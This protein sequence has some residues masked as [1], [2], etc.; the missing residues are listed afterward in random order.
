MLSQQGGL[1]KKKEIEEGKLD[2]ALTEER[3]QESPSRRLE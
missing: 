2:A 1:K 3:E